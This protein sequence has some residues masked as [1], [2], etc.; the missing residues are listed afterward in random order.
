M[1]TYRK[2]VLLY[3]LIE[4]EG[5]RVLFSFVLALLST[6]D[7]FS[8][9]WSFY[10]QTRFFKNCIP[11]QYKMCNKSRIPREFSTKECIVSQLKFRPQNGFNCL[12]VIPLLFQ[13]F[14]R[15]L[16]MKNITILQNKIMKTHSH[17]K[18]ND[19]TQT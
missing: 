6:T 3:L 11:S 13:F 10:Q 5:S 1:L 9:E 18:K 4:V 2:S 7:L 16:F 19:F 15:N 12:I 8:Y 14:T 17:G